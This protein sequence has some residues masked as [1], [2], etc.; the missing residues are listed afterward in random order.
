MYIF[1][2]K[3]YYKNRDKQV[4]VMGELP[5]IQQLKYFI[6]Y[7]RIQNFTQAAEEAN[8]T[9][10][11]FSAQMKKLEDTLGVQL[12]QRSN[13]GSHLTQEGE[14]F[15]EKIRVWMEHLQEIVYD[16]QSETRHL[17]VELHVGILR[18][19]G[20]VLMNTHV[21]YFQQH[22]KNIV[23]NVYDMEEEELLADLHADR[24]DIA[25]TYLVKEAA[26]AEYERRYFCRDRMAYYAPCLENLPASVDRMLLRRFPLVYYPPKYFMNEAFRAYFSCTGRLPKLAARL[27]TPYA[28]IHY[29]RQNPVGALLPERLLHALGNEQGVYELQEPFELDA[30]LVY[31][32]EN[33]KAR[34]I[35][36]YVDYILELFAKRQ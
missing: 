28:M 33:P 36:V 5:S 7:G 14:L 1:V 3:K 17:P 4:V 32:R 16:F 8:I 30:C 26:F 12:I 10:S 2:M 9:Q 11:A 23:L 6:V 27:S 19:L 13:R 34:S 21:A 18:T 22:D 20:D 29:C 24:I 15:L 31:K 35:S 25:S